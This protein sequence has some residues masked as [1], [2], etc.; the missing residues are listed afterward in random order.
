MIIAVASSEK[1][2]DAKVSGCFGRTNYVFIA[3]T[4]SRVIK[5]LDTSKIAALQFE[6]GPQSAELLIRIG[7]DCAA[8]VLFDD[9]SREILIGKGIKVLPGV[10]GTAREIIEY[11][12]SGGDIEKK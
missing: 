4:V 7:V 12:A 5:I 9:E 8:A 6:S 1:N 10:S 11:I 3:D 2:F